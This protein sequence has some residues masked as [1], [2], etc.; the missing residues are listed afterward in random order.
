MLV[1]AG[2][3][4]KKA[5]IDGPYACSAPEECM[6]DCERIYLF[7]GSEWNGTQKP[8]EVTQKRRRKRPEPSFHFARC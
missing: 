8:L 2:R 6:H 1:N 7:G 5:A 4:Y 3:F